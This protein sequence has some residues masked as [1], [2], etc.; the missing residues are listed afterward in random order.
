MGKTHNPNDTEA[1]E[2]M[3]EELREVSKIDLNRE[4]ILKTLKEARE[5]NKCLLYDMKMLTNDQGYC[6]IFYPKHTECP[7]EGKLVGKDYDNKCIY[8][9][10]TL[11]ELWDTYR[12]NVENM[13]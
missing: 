2:L 4:I 10:K 11:E 8:H 3:L 13:K 1:V 5:E 6:L 9:D 12:K 7:S